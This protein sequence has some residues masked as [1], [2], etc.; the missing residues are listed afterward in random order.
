MSSYT[1]KLLVL[2]GLTSDRNTV[3]KFREPKGTPRDALFKT[4]LNGTYRKPFLIEDL[5]FRAMCF[6]LDGCTQTEMRLD[7]PDALA[8]E[9]TRKMMGFLL[10]DALPKKVLMIGLG[11]G[12]LA[13]YCHR[14]LP[15]TQLTVIEID[16]DVIA[17]RSHFYMPPDDERL[18]VINADGADYVAQMT[19]LGERADVVLVDAYDDFGIAR[20]VVEREF[21][22]NAKR[23][24]NANGVF[25]LNLVAGAEDFNRYVETIRQVFGS[26]VIVVA[27][28][29]GGN[30]VVFAGNELLDPYRMPVALHNAEQVEARLGLLFPTLLQHLNE[31][32]QRKAGSIPCS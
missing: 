3:F 14:Y 8:N 2:G 25:V 26:P 18:K 17:M 11:G 22:E 15:T 30:R 10:F 9:Y 28:K 31:S 5:E 13:K 24:L 29:Q 7:D 32:H 4:L 6:T 16:P 27:M 19:D 21:V 23:V 20:S 12:A 1:Q